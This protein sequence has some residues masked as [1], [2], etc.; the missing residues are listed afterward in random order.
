MVYITGD[1]H[2]DIAPI[3]ALWEKFHP[4]KNDIIII[5]G[6]QV[7]TIQDGCGTGF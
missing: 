6:D 3:Y 5:L 4:T 2:G 1:I 7:S